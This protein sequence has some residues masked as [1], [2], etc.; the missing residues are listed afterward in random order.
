MRRVHTLTF[1]LVLL[2]FLLA[3]FIQRQLVQI[4]TVQVPCQHLK[5]IDAL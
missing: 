5:D 3:Q 2:L 1:S 4:D